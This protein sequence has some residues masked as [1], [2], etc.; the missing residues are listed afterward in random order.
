[1]DVRKRRPVLEVEQRERFKVPGDYICATSELVVLVRL[2][3]AHPQAVRTEPPDLEFT[4]RRVD[5]IDLSVTARG[6]TTSVDDLDLN[7]EPHRRREGDKHLNRAVRSRLDHLHTR[8]RD[9]RLL[10]KLGECPSSSAALGSKLT[11]DQREE[12]TRTAP[13]PLAFDLGSFVVTFQMD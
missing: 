6:A 10:G 1:V 9:G 5:G 4:H 13:Q 3:H 11:T 8:T 7:V 2:I 12:R